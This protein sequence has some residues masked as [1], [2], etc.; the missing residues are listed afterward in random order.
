MAPASYLQQLLVNHPLKI[1]FTIF[2]SLLISFIYC[3]VNINNTA[4]VVFIENTLHFMTTHP[5][6]LYF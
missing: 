5:G 2:K 1:F 3:K 4:A 6:S